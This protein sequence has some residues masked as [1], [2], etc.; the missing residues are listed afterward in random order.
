MKTIFAIDGLGPWLLCSAIAHGVLVAG[1]VQTPG[2]ELGDRGGGMPTLMVSIQSQQSGEQ[3]TEHSVSQI[4]APLAQVGP[5]AAMPAQAEQHVPMT[6][7]ENP[8]VSE[9]KSP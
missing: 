2:T 8:S 7:K 1:L 5:V 6:A 9:I 4:V 3:T